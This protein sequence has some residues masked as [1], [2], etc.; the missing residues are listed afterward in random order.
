MPRLIAVPD[1]SCSG[2]QTPQILALS[3][4]LFMLWLGM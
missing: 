1:A 4:G 2:Q 3:A